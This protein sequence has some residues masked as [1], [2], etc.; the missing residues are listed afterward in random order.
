MK[1]KIFPSNL[2]GTIRAPSSKSYTH[3]AIILATLAEGESTIKKPLIAG[4]T[5]STIDACTQLGSEIGGGPNALKISGRDSPLTPQDIIDVKNS[6][7]TLRFITAVSSLAPKGYTVLTG[8]RSIRGRPMMHLLNSLQSLGV[9]CW[10]TQLNGLP[11]IV[12]RG[13]GIMG[14]NSE[15][16]GELSS[17]FL[18]GIL[19]ASAKANDQVVIRIRGRQV[20]RPY[21]DATIAL[22]RHFSGRVEQLDQN[23]YKVNPRQ[24]FEPKIF[25]VPGDFS[26]ASLMLAIGLLGGEKVTVNNLDFSLPQGDERIVNM[27]NALGA[28]VE[29]DRDAGSLTVAGGERLGSGNFDLSDTPDLL[30]VLAVLALKADGKI[31][32]R[33]VEHT[34]FK[35][36]DRISVLANELKRVGCRVDERRTG[37]SI[38]APRELEGTSLDSHGDHR[39]FMAFVG[40]ALSTKKEF[41]VDGLES[42]NVSYPNFLNDLKTLGC[43]FE[44]MDN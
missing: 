39:L 31:S 10:S 17:Q 3:R 15:I 23:T 8:D 33:G 40:A 13:G 26:S 16:N 6:G 18:S 5:Q 30:P 20:S 24:R 14:G 22:M 41:V 1:L 7:T 2:K 35:E 42:V 37:L 4:D 25:T 32:I 38:Q 11:P 34:R 27:L 36:T 28:P 29:T 43:E 44:V 19:L 21:V 12:V 9:Q